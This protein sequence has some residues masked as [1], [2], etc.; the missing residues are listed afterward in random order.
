MLLSISVS[1]SLL[2]DNFAYC[3]L[4]AVKSPSSS[5]AYGARHHNCNRRIISGRVDRESLESSHTEYR[6]YRS[7]RPLRNCQYTNNSYVINVITYSLCVSSSCLWCYQKT[8]VRNLSKTD[9]AKTQNWWSWASFSEY[10]F[11]R[12]PCQD[13][14]F[15]HRKVLRLQDGTNTSQSARSFCLHNSFYN[16][17]DLPEKSLYLISK[18]EEN[19]GQIS[20]QGRVLRCT[21]TRY[22]N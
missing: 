16:N 9:I 7:H 20:N 1:I 11:L 6:I 22:F 18:I 12:A 5:P 19:G 2:I 21:F 8:Y 3:I 4:R 17:K 15:P 13:F 14:E 10:G